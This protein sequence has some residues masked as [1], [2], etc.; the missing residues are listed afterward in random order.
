[1][2]V[3]PTLMKR[4]RRLVQKTVFLN[5]V[6]VKKKKLAISSHKMERFINVSGETKPMNL[7]NR[8]NNFLNRAQ[9][10]P[11]KSRAEFSLPPTQTTWVDI[12][13]STRETCCKVT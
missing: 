7:Q 11:P 3:S 10:L 9:S 8:K 5:R 1:M 6:G 2:V 4:F 12:F 13:P